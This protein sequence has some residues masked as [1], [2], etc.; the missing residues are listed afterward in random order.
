ME[1]RKEKKAM[2]ITVRSSYGEKKEDARKH[3]PL[4]SRRWRRDV[5]AVLIESCDKV[6]TSLCQSFV[7]LA[8]NRSG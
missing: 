8:L 6:S 2:E 3:E 4:W 7:A 5:V 1:R